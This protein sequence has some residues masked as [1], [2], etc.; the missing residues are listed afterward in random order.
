[1]VFLKSDCKPVSMLVHDSLRQVAMGPG[2]QVPG[3]V[4]VPVVGLK[5]GCKPVSIVVHDSL[6][7]VATGHSVQGPGVFGCQGAGEDG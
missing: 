3:G 6:R 5:P 4:Q 7:Q 1:M 2:V